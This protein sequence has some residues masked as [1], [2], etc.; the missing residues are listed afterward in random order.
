MARGKSSRLCLKELECALDSDFLTRLQK[1]SEGMKQ[2]VRRRKVPLRGEDVR[3]ARK[4]LKFIDS[5]TAPFNE[6]R[7]SL[8]AGLPSEKWAMVGLGT[9]HG[10]KS[11]ADQGC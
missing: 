5:F 2:T 11:G 4:L 1:V 8:I 7:A 3:K 10:E 9:N 6:I